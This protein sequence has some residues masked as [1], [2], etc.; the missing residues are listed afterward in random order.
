MTDIFDNTH[1]SGTIGDYY[2]STSGDVS[3]SGSAALASTDYGLQVDIASGD[4]STDFGTENSVGSTG[5]IRVRLYLDPNS[6]SMPNNTTIAIADCRLSTTPFTLFGAYIK[7]LNAQGYQLYLWS[8]NDSGTYAYTT[9]VNITDAEHYLEIWVDRASSSSASDGT[10]NWSIDGV[11]Q[12]GITGIDN[13]DNFSIHTY[14]RFGNTWR[15]S[16]SI[17]GTIYLDEIKCVDNDSTIGP[18]SSGN[19]QAAAG[20]LSFAGAVVKKASFDYAGAISPA[21]AATKKTSVD[22]AGALPSAGTLAGKAKKV[23]AGAISFAGGVVRKISAG[24]YGSLSSAGALIKKGFSALS[25]ALSPSGAVSY[26]IVIQQAISGALSFTGN[27]AKKTGKSISGALSSSGAL[28][29]KTA[30]SLAGVL[31]SS[32][33]VNGI[34][35]GAGIFY[36]ALSGALS[37]SGEITKKTASSH[38]G[39]ITPAGTLV[40][41]AFAELAGALSSGGAVT[42]RI[43]IQK[44]LAA[45]LTFSGAATGK[46]LKVISGAVSFVGSPV[47]KTAKAFSGGL[48][49]VGTLIKKGF[50]ALAGA[51]D[52]SGAV[53]TVLEALAEFSGT[54]SLSLGDRDLGVTLSDRGLVIHLLNRDIDL[55]LKDK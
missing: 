33:A 7:Y 40:K 55:T 24:F 49:S 54:Y 51:A 8:R 1:E 21:G 43:V 39:E 45:A 17:S 6:V 4:A 44:A 32:G 38:S 14:W 46:A 23:L 36:Q 9:A 10:L 27:T 13:Y 28:I 12:T 52:F 35:Q 11:S 5:H 37:P 25:G 34:K 18:V 15:S 41:K 53:S 22:Y 20:V 19:N 48:S 50:V 2:D 26:R 47:K 16:T 29:M 30:A 42:S 3:L 31:S